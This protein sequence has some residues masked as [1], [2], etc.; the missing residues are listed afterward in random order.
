MTNRNFIDLLHSIFWK[1]D[2]KDGVAPR[3]VTLV[4]IFLDFV[5]NSSKFLL[6]F[7]YLGKRMRITFELFLEENSCGSS[8]YIWWGSDRIIKQVASSNERFFPKQKMTSSVN[9]TF[10]SVLSQQS[11]IHS[12]ETHDNF[13]PNISKTSNPGTSSRT[14][15]R[16]LFLSMEKTLPPSLHFNLQA[17]QQNPS[18][19]NLLPRNSFTFTTVFRVLMCSS[20][21]L[22][23]EENID[24]PNC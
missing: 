14:T 4:E 22:A 21:L 18:F 15:I 24:S 10:E 13:L 20:C 16:D 19:S 12:K 8:Q 5:W 1:I 2:S 23:E 17:L 9:S 6:N 11:G 7:A 3:K